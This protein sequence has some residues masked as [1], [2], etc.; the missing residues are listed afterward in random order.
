[1]ENYQ[2]LWALV[3]EVAPGAELDPAAL[4]V[5]LEAYRPKLLALFR[6]KVRPGGAQQ[7]EAAQRPAARTAAARARA[8]GRCCRAATAAAAARAG[9]RAARPTA[10]RSAAAVPAQGPDA[11][12]RAQVQRGRVATPS[13]GEV[14]LDRDPDQHWVVELSDKLR[15]D[16]VTCVELLAYAQEMWGLGGLEAAFGTYLLE[17]LDAARA[18][19]RLLALQL[20]HQLEVGQAGE[21]EGD[22]SGGA[23]GGASGDGISGS[24]AALMES[25]PLLAVVSRFN[26]GLLRAEEGGKNTLVARL[27]EAVRDH[28]LDSLGPSFAVALDQYGCQASR[29]WYIQQAPP[30]P[31]RAPPTRRAR[32]PPL[33]GSQERGELCRALLYAVVLSPTPLTPATLAEL[34]QLLEAL[35]GKVKAAGAS[36]PHALLQQATSCLFAVITAVSLGNA[37]GGAPRAPATLAQLLRSPDLA[38]HLQRVSKPEDGFA[39]LV[40]LAVG[41]TR[42]ALAT[43]RAGGPLAGGVG[44]APPGPLD[45]SGGGAAAP[46]ALLEAAGRARALGM[47]SWLLSSTAFALEPEAGHKALAARMAYR[48]ITEMLEFDVASRRELTESLIRESRQHQDRGVSS[49]RGGAFLPL[50]GAGGAAAPGASPGPGTPTGAQGG[51]GLLPAPGAAAGGAAAAAPGGGGLAPQDDLSSLLEAL[52]VVFGVRPGLWFDGEAPESYPHVSSFMSY[53][54]VHP[55]MQLPDVRVS[56]LGVLA[57]LAAGPRGSRFCLA[58]FRQNAGKPELEHFTWRKLFQSIVVYCRRYEE[59]ER[60]AIVGGS[61]VVATGLLAARDDALMPPGDAALLVA[62]LDLLGKIIDQ[63]AEQEVRAELQGLERDVSSVLGGLPLYEPLFQLMCHGVPSSVKAAVHRSLGCLAR[64]KELAPRLLE[65]LLVAAVVASPQGVMEGYAGLPRFDLLA[66]VNEV[67]ARAEEYS[68]SLA[69]LGFVNRLLAALGPA[70]LPGGGLAVGHYTAAVLQHVLERAL[71]QH[72]LQPG[73]EE[74]AA[75]MEAGSEG[76]PRQAAVLEGLRLLN[77]ALEYDTAAAEQLAGLSVRERL[78]PLHSLLLSPARRLPTLLQYLL[79]P[80]EAVQLEAAKLLAALAARLPNLVPLLQPNFDDGPALLVRQGA[81]QSLELALLDHAGPGGFGGAA[82]EAGKADGP[83][84]DGAAAGGGAPASPGDARAELLL[85]VMLGTLRG[86]PPPTL[87]H[88]LLG[89]DTTAPPADWARV[90]LAPQLEFTCM[91]VLLRALQ[92]APLQRLKP[93][94]YAKALQLLYAVAAEPLTCEPAFRLLHPA[95]AAGGLL[96]GLGALLLEPLDGEGAHAVASLRQRAYVLRLYALALLRC[97]QRAML[98]PLLAAL[99]CPPGAGG[100]P[101]SPGTPRGGA[102]GGG[103]GGGA[104]PAALAALQAICRVPLAEPSLKDVPGELLALQQEMAADDVS[105]YALLTQPAAM[106]AAGLVVADD[107]GQ[108]IFDFA[109]LQRLLHERYDEYVAKAGGRGGER[110]ALARCAVAAAFAHAQQVN[111]HALLAGAQRAAVAGWVQAVEVAL[112]KCYALVNTKTCPGGGPELLHACLLGTLGLVRDLAGQQ[113]G[114][115]AEA[116]AGCCRVL[117]SKLQ[118]LASASLSLGLPGDPLSQV[119]L[120]VRCLALL[121]L[122][123]ECLLGAGSHKGLRCEMYVALLQYLHFCRGSK[124]GDCPPLVLSCLIA[125]AG[126][127]TSAAQLDA[128]Q[129]ALEQGNGTVLRP[130]AGDLVGLMAADVL[131]PPERGG[132]AQAVALHL[133]AALVAADPSS[134]ALADALHRANVPR[135]LLAC[136]TDH[137]PHILLQPASKSQAALLVLEAQLSL[138][139]ALAAA[140]GPGARKGSTKAVAD[141]GALPYL[142][143]CRALDYAP[144][145]PSS[146]QRLKKSGALRYRL[147]HLVCPVLRLVLALLAGAPGSSG[148][149]EQAAAFAASHVDL[150]ARLLQEAAAPGTPAWAPGDEELEQAALA[151]SLLAALPG[152]LLAAPGAGGA[153]SALAGLRRDLWR[154]VLVLGGHDRKDGGGASSIVAQLR[155]DGGAGGGASRAKQE[156]RRAL[157]LQLRCGLA[158]CLREAVTPPPPGA[159]GKGKGPAVS[160]DLLVCVGHQAQVSGVD[161]GHGSPPL[162]TGATGGS[163]GWQG[164]LRRRLRH[165]LPWCRAS[166]AAPHHCRRRRRRRQ[167]AVDA[168]GRPTLL[169][170]RDTADQALADTGA[171]AEELEGLLAFLRAPD[172]LTSNADVAAKLAAWGPGLAGLGG[173]AADGAA[174]ADGDG[175]S[176]RALVLAGEPGADGGALAAAAGAFAG[177]DPAAARRLARQCAA[178][179]AAALLSQLRQQLHLVEQCLAIVLLH[180]VQCLPRPDTAAVMAASEGGGGPGGDAMALDGGAGAGGD[181]LLPSPGPEAAA[182]LGSAGDLQ[183]FAGK[184]RDVCSGADEAVSHVREL[185]AVAGGGGPGAGGAPLGGEEYGESCDSLELLN[186]QLKAYLASL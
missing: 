152:G 90:G 143:A 78:A 28:T 22:V 101:G 69:F 104:A 136:V 110:E 146:H 12:L 167:T 159:A 24:L 119:R 81:A 52:A 111:A 4:Q 125:G 9:R 165:R 141:A 59:L 93:A 130:L 96:P 124:L 155:R 38:P 77:S 74:L 44:A 71:L 102:G 83:P 8:G 147:V 117:L 65:R 158:A 35:A 173:G 6:N 180:F 164:P 10:A 128:L 179:G 13:F 15:L 168:M 114:E 70:S 151:V 171:L 43:A 73:Q 137:A 177:L 68:E 121:R 21:A 37:A 126:P 91:T 153:G 45:A 174:D 56:F 51:L 49:S 33:R 176:S 41:L 134:T 87:G 160:G 86:S 54:A 92:A 133:L 50:G 11:G 46:A 184:M 163:G 183:F 139:L 18:L 66:Q 178:R 27:I 85:D 19:S 108:P 144:E 16:E 67:E 5:E 149:A 127:G 57:A 172:A 100:A 132:T 30:A 185:L 17:R 118:E 31:S 95:E 76:P 157:L 60:E 23:G 123:L 129:A 40:A 3:Q 105:V 142:T 63:G 122:L 135:G 138:L 36:A 107:Y 47:L 7:R 156:R 148:L 75:S 14:P 169:L 32:A 98:E 48:L 182:R 84:A 39:A 106:E 115:L 120:P 112:T 89:F 131:Q 99:L 2:Q 150:L 103:F 58:Q 145:Q 94:L 166:S 88:L 154:L 62:Y 42:D 97:E 170:V 109:V 34:L 1:M 29:T 161:A 113:A 186:R 20:F 25:Q 79:Y 116:L 82:E 181:Q 80:D 72:V 64:F 53:V 55:A 140:G 175:T 26:E 61:S 162:R